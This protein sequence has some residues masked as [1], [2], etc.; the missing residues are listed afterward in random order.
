MTRRLLLFAAAAVAVPLLLAAVRPPKSSRYLVVWAMQARH[1]HAQFTFI[2]G[3]ETK[4]G[5]ARD[6]LAVYSVSPG[7]KS[8]GKLVGFLPA[9]QAAMAHHANYAMPPNDILYTNDYLANRTDVFNLQNP[10][11]PRLLRQFRGEAG[12]SY[13]HS[14]AYLPGGDTLATF[15]FAS[16]WGRAPG[17]LVEFAPRG[18]VVRS[19]SAAAAGHPHAYPYSLAAVPSLNRVVTGTMGM[20]PA[21]PG[22]HTVQIWRLSDLTLLTTLVLPGGAMDANEPRVLA[23][24][25]T[26]V[27][28]TD[29]CDLFLLHRLDSPHPSLQHIYRFSGDKCGVPIVVDNYLL[30][31]SMLGHAIV[32]LDMSHPEHPRPA[33]EIVFPPRE[34]PHWLAVEPGGNRI[35]ITGYGSMITK[36][37]FAQINRRTGQLRLLTQALDLSARHWP[38][39]WDG[40]AIPHAAV[41]SNQ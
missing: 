31:P 19:R 30:E 24:G 15:Q 40:S 13:P 26:V 29:H 2:P 8:F 23:D 14:F 38:D 37:L 10:R 21:V 39:G 17:G 5:L 32:S 9:G 16:A 33:G 1:P 4:L 28:P 7:S 12:F 41:F 35:A 20:T 11:H 22:S 36:V 6:F 18:R 25:K 27:V 3:G 34:L